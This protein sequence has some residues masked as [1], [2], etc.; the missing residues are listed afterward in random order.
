MRKLIVAHICAFMVFGPVYGQ[1]ESQKQEHEAELTFD[2]PRVTVRAGGFKRAQQHVVAGPI[3]FVTA[4][5]GEGLII[6]VLDL[7]CVVIEVDVGAT[8]VGVAAQFGV[9]HSKAGEGASVAGLALSI[10]YLSQIVVAP[11]VLVMAVRAG[12][13]R[14]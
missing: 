7:V 10:A 5:A 6:E 14:P 1:V 2:R 9:P 12:P 4:Q 8:S 3:G 13:V 11:S